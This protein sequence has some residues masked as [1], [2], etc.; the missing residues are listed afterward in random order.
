MNVVKKRGRKPKNKII[1]NDNPCFESN[2][3]KDVIIKIENI[4][5]ENIIDE[6]IIDKNIIDKNIIYDNISDNIINNNNSDKLNTCKNCKENIIDNHILPIKYIDNI[7]YI[8]DNFCCKKCCKK[9]IFKN[10]KYNNY[11]LYSLYKLYYNLLDKNM[12]IKK[13]YI[14]NIN[15]INNNKKSNIIEN[16]NL[17]LFRG[18]KD[19]N[20]LDF[21]NNI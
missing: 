5:D 1:I 14:N 3:N 21:I 2:N 6:N 8:N 19:N 18:K 11:E 15:N 9:Y 16:K 13:V 20:I 17:K 7:F 4:I 12:E 10:S